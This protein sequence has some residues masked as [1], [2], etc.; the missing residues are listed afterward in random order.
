MV[1]GTCAWQRGGGGDQTPPFGYVGEKK[2]EQCDYGSSLFYFLSFLLARKVRKVGHV[3]GCPYPAYGKLL[4]QLFFLWGRGR[5]GV[6]EWDFFQGWRGMMACIQFENTLKTPGSKLT[7]KGPSGSNSIPRQHCPENRSTWR[8]IW[9]RAG[10]I[11]PY[12]VFVKSVENWPNSG[13]ILTRN[14]VWPQIDPFPGHV[15]PGVFRVYLKKIEKSC[16]ILSA[17]Q[18][19][20][21]WYF[22]EY[23]HI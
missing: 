10:S 20:V 3:G 5:K 16:M 12:I 13:S 2:Y 23:R 15:D 8:R 1:A 6:G 17:P 21:C 14:W 7:R 11:W 4:T 18:I 19:L 9:P 22:V